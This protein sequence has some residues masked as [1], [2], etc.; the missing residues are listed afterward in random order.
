LGTVPDE[1]SRQWSASLQIIEIIEDHQ[2]QFNNNPEL[3]EFKCSINDDE[4]EVI[5]AY[6]NLMDFIEQH[7]G[8]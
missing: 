7:V 3:L 5:I 4:Y 6:N 2:E 8:V 1:A